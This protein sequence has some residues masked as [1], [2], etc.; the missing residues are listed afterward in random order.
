VQSAVS[1]ETEESDRKEEVW[2]VGGDTPRGSGINR[3]VKYYYL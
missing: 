2:P 3:I 1:L